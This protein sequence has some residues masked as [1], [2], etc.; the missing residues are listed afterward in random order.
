MIIAAAHG[1]FTQSVPAFDAGA[2]PLFAEL[3]PNISPA[4]GLGS[5]W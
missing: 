4:R 2:L 3:L 1:S 5:V